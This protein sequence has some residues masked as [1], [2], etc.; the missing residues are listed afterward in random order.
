MTPGWAGST[1]AWGGWGASGASHTS[2]SSSNTGAG[3]GTP[4]YQ[5]TGSQKS[6]SSSSSTGWRV[7]DAE[8]FDAIACLL[9]GL[10]APVAGRKLADPAAK[11]PA[12]EAVRQAQKKI[13]KWAT[14][15][16]QKRNS[17]PREGP[18]IKLTERPEARGRSTKFFHSEAGVEQKKLMGGVSRFGLASRQDQA[19]N[20]HLMCRDITWIFLHTTQCELN[21]TV[22][23]AIRHMG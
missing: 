7:G 11:E 2:S 18:A 21:R 23:L 6:S 19:A 17:H 16:V 13:K 3:W 10:N 1:P 20:Q 5:S 15:S 22:V 8:C 14:P 9:Q 4:A 12:E